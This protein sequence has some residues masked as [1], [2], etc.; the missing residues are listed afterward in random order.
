LSAPWSL[1]GVSAPPQEARA[2]IEIRRD[3]IVLRAP[4]GAATDLPSTWLTL[5]FAP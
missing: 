1:L 4:P 5:R 3:D 2:L